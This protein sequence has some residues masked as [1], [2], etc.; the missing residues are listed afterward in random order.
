M[1]PHTHII[2]PSLSR[3]AAKTRHFRATSC[4]LHAARSR[5]HKAR[6]LFV[7]RN[8]FVLDVARRDFSRFT[9]ATT[10]HS[11]AVAGVHFHQR[12]GQSA[13]NKGDGQSA[14]QQLVG[15]KCKRLPMC[16]CRRLF[17]VC[18]FAKRHWQAEA[19]RE[20]SSCCRC[21]LSSV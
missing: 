14:Q 13:S 12:G 17:I 21:N 6:G 16:R 10:F 5:A 18:E 3:S 4:N 11:P 9:F 15:N 1:K 2:W 8:E 20:I 7:L 19:S